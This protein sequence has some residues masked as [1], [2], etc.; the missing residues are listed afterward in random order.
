VLLAVLLIAGDASSGHTSPGVT[1][2]FAIC[3]TLPCRP[4]TAVLYRT[5]QLL[6]ATFTC[7]VCLVVHTLSAGQ[8]LSSKAFVLADQGSSTRFF[9]LRESTSSFNEV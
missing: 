5:A 1:Y 6:D 9:F 3:S 4:A 7:L 2:A 8:V